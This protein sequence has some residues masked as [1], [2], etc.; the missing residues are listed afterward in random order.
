MNDFM[1]RL[2][3]RN[4]NTGF[5]LIIKGEFMNWKKFVLPPLA[6]YAVIFLFISALVGAN[7][8]QHATWVWV[9]SIIIS[10]VGLFFA[11][12]FAKP[13]NWKGGLIYGV[14]WLVIFFVLDLIL[15][16]PFTGWGYFSDPRSY[17][18][19]VLTLLIPTFSARK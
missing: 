6:I 8:D 18:P 5:V 14:V 19:Y 10:I 15:T 7:I 11:A 17:L 3:A 16:V 12:N 4:E 1:G 13:K 9:V 2:I